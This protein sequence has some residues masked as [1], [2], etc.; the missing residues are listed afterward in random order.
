[1]LRTFA[2]LPIRITRR[3]L[4]ITRRVVA[5][6]P[7][8]APQ[9][10]PDPAPAPAA[11]PAPTSPAAAPVPLRVDVTP[12][13]HALKFT[14]PFPVV[15][16]GSL[17]FNSVTSASNHPIGRALFSIEGVKLVFAVHDFVTVTKQDDATWESLRSRIEVALGEALSAPGV[18]G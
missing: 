4:R 2:R 10:A 3:L 14:A 13:P 15:A 9:T 16:K 17:S 6:G 18:R 11:A 12:N 7:P 5:G 8:A 1:M